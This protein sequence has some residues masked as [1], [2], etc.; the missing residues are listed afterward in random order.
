MEPDNKQAHKFAAF[1][2]AHLARLAPAARVD[3]L[4]STNAEWAGQLRQLHSRLMS[5]GPGLFLDLGQG[6]TRA[7]SSKSRVVAGVSYAFESRWSHPSLG[8]GQLVPRHPESRGEEARRHAECTLLDALRLCDAAAPLDTVTLDAS[9]LA[10]VDAFW[11]TMRLLSSGRFGTQPSSP[12]AAAQA[13]ARPEWFRGCGW[14]S[15]GA[16]VAARL[17]LLLAAAVQA[18]CVPGVVA[19]PAPPLRRVPESWWRSLP[20]AE[21]RAMLAAE[22]ATLGNALRQRGEL[23][24]KQWLQHR[25]EQQLSEDGADTEI[26]LLTQLIEGVVGQPPIMPGEPD[27]RTEALRAFGGFGGIPGG[28]VDGRASVK[29]A[30]IAG[31]DAIPLLLRAGLSHDAEGFLRLLHERPLR[32]V[33]SPLD[34]LCRSLAKRLAAKYSAHLASELVRDEAEQQLRRRQEAEAM[35]AVTATK[36]AVAATRSTKRGGKKGRPAPASNARTSEKAEAVTAFSGRA[37]QVVSDD[38]EDGADEGV[39]E[40]TAE[41]S[42]ALLAATN[43]SRVAAAATLAATPAAAPPG[44]KPAAAAVQ[45]ASNN[46]ATAKQVPAKE[47]ALTADDGWT[48]VGARA[49]GSGGVSS[50]SGSIGNGAAANA[51]QPAPSVDV[52]TRSAVPLRR[53]ARATPSQARGVATPRPTTKGG[54]T[55]ATT[56]TQP[57]PLDP[58]S[59]WAKVAA[60]RAAVPPPPPSTPLRPLQTPPPPTLPTS[61]HTPLSATAGTSASVAASASNAINALVPASADI[62]TAERALVVSPPPTAT[63]G[64]CKRSPPRAPPFASGGGPPAPP[65]SP[66]ALDLS[67]WPLI[68]ELASELTP[69]ATLTPPYMLTPPGARTPPVGRK[70]HSRMCGCDGCGGSGPSSGPPSRRHSHPI[71]GALHQHLQP[72]FDANALAQKLGGRGVGDG[73]G[74]YEEDRGGEGYGSPSEESQPTRPRCNSAGAS[75]IPEARSPHSGPLPRHFARDRGVAPV[76]AV[77]RSAL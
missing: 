51:A 48:A 60:P 11:S 10:D 57:V 12:A 34:Q 22:F 26:G 31:A 45:E 77:E 25:Q 72:I 71:N 8:G 1:L 64:S 33:H 30:P 16:F 67:D 52:P 42:L 38:D 56:A 15:L 23:K 61:A 63:P 4:R 24:R 20:H 44:E 47:D 76:G 55:V 5:E 50:T 66:P 17:H 58:N 40:D 36:D 74:A 54:V 19:P 39:A 65:P 2:R 59:S 13:S 73:V 32:R 29:A 70:A 6:G 75:R 28:L 69:P 62:A 43:K 3:I 49:R 46:G 27:A 14:F 18:A 68:D 9:L 53:G 41:E 37:A 35:A 7:R 21:R